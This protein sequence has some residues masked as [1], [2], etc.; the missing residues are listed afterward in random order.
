LGADPASAVANIADR[1]TALVARSHGSDIAGTPVGGMR[2]VDYLPTRTFELTVH[3]AD[4]ALATGSEFNVPHTAGGQSLELVAQ[5]ATD[6]GHAGTLLLAATGRGA[7]P[8]GSTV[9]GR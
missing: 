6:A 4:L 7:L 8:D 2:L 5:L 1:V 3:T 9:L